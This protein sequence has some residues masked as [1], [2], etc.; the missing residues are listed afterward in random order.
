MS[1]TRSTKDI[2]KHFDTKFLL[3]NDV[4]NVTFPRVLI[5]EITS[6]SYVGVRCHLRNMKRMSFRAQT[7]TVPL[8]RYSGKW[9]AEMFLC[10]TRKVRDS[11][12]SNAN[13]WSAWSNAINLKIVSLPA[14]LDLSLQKRT[15]Q[16]T[17]GVYVFIETR[18]CVR[19]G[20][21]KARCFENQLRSEIL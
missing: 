17:T 19:E 20:I 11:Q 2:K 16:W 6:F 5:K 4:H 13:V 1:I 14:F 10:R 18:A 9:P 8:S 15:T 3:E 7:V 12:R 21:W